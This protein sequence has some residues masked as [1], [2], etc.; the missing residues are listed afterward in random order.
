MIVMRV[1]PI[2]IPSFEDLRLPPTLAKI[3]DHERGM[4]LVTG[5]TGA[6]KSSTMAAVIDWINKHKP[7]HIVTLENPIEFLH[8]DQKSSITQRDI[9]RDT[10]SFMAGLRAALR[11][12]P[13]GLPHR[14]DARQGDH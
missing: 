6:G 14:R 1:I 11:Q 9:G 7:L 4:I 3:A 13:D 8:R 2:E 10:P 5:V 12:D